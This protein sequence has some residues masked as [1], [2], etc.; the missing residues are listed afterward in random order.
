MLFR[1]KSRKLRGRYSKKVAEVMCRLSARLDF[2]EAVDEL[3]RQGIEVSHT[4]LLVANG[5]P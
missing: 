1:K 3:K 2:R 4:T 5:S